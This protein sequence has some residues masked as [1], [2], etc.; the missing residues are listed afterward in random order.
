MGYASTESLFVQSTLSNAVLSLLS[1]RTGSLGS[2][3]VSIRIEQATC[4]NTF[5]SSVV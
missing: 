4:S 5:E 1:A 2:D 3:L